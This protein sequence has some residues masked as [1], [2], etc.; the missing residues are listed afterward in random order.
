LSH[1]K[2]FLLEQPITSLAICALHHLFNRQTERAKTGDFS[3]ESL[4]SSDP[5]T[6]LGYEATG[7]RAVDDAKQGLAGLGQEAGRL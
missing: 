7:E 5:L 2:P 1:T 3:A 4:L 6:L